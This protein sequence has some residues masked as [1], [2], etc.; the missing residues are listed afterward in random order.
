MAKFTKQKRE[1][2][3]A[4]SYTLPWRD[5]YYSGHYDL[6]NYSLP[7]KR[8]RQLPSIVSKH[9]HSKSTQYIIPAG[10]GNYGP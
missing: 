5:P 3:T 8:T 7:F 1:L 9:G 10:Y 4:V 6:F 2:P